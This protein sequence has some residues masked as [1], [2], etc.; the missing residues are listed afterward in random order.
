MASGLTKLAGLNTVVH[1]LADWCIAWADYYG[2]PVTVTS[3]FRSWSDQ[4]RLYTNYVEC[5]RTGSYGKTP[6]CQYPAN[7]PGDSA[8]NYGLAWDSVVP[9]QYLSWWNAVRAA[10]GF[11]LYPDD[12]VHAEVPEWRRIVGQSS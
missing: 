7:K 1:Q 10:A 4:E 2:V 9:Q 8:H 11:K 5:L 12:P 3:G 6:D